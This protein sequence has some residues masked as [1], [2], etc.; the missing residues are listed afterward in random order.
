MVKQSGF[1]GGAA[2]SQY[3]E[4]EYGTDIA[5]FDVPTKDGSPGV[6]QVGGDA[7]A[8]F[9]DTPAVRAFVNYLTSG[10]GARMWA[11]SGFDLSPNSKVT[12]LSYTDD[13]ASDKA[14]A[15]AKASAVCFDI[16]DVLL[17]G[18]NM[19][20]FAALTE[21]VNGG[22]LATILQRLEDR[23]VEVYD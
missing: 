5:F 14:N 19:D 18:I 13:I 10:K 7:M 2:M 21:Y 23:M 1:G 9:N 4:L 17:G 11:A 8:V 3:P 16:G 12:G 22:D 6:M 15:L 20:E